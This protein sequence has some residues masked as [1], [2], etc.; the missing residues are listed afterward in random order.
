MTKES[1]FI[2]V[3]CRSQTQKIFRNKNWQNKWHRNFFFNSELYF[4]INGS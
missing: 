3:S 4:R 2:E 1:D